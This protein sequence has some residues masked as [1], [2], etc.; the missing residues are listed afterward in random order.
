MYLAIADLAG[1]VHFSFSIIGNGVLNNRRN[2]NLREIYRNILRQ[3]TYE[4][5]PAKF[6]SR[7]A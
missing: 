3:A 2:F 6:P 7:D 1:G 5:L 4:P